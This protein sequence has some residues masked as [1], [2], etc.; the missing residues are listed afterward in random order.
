LSIEEGGVV[1]SVQKGRY[2]LY[3]RPGRW[4]REK[5]K[6]ANLAGMRKKT[7]LMKQGGTQMD[8]STWEK[9]IEE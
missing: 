2:C 6:R 9:Q 5:E 3:R 8:Y 7:T 4:K 1:V